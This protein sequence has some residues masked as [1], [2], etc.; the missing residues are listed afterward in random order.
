MTS[1]G[2]NTNKRVTF[3]TYLENR[4]FSISGVIDSPFGDNKDKFVVETRGIHSLTSGSKT[5]IY[6]KS[7]REEPLLN[8]P[9]LILFNL[10]LK[11]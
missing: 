3:S 9:R 8:F 2:Q 6:V 1:Q 10:L 11:S 7:F 5:Y 4:F